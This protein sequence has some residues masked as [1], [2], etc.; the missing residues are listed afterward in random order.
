[1]D[2]RNRYGAILSAAYV[3][4]V[5]VTVICFALW[6]FGASPLRSA[7]SLLAVLAAESAVYFSA[8]LWLRSAARAG[9]ASPALLTGMLIALLYLLAAG[10]AAAILDGLLELGAFAY[11][12]V[13]LVLLMV[14]A[15]LL[16]TTGLYSWNASAQEGQTADATSSLRRQLEELGEIRQIARAWKRPEAALLAG[17]VGDL[18][19]QFKYSDPVSDPELRAT[20]NLLDQQISL[21]H[22]HVSLL[23][24][25]LEPSPEWEGDTRGLTDSISAT[26]Q[27]RNR[28]LAALK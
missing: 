26:L 16:G 15:I 5:I 13:Q 17:I 2:K 25:L 9:G 20:E 27:R 8:R 24:S 21:L 14:A 6:G 19:E 4:A 7:V 28:E 23:L 22:D 12:A 3:A 11:A 10:A 1:M 18:E